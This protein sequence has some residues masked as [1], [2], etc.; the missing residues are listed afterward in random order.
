MTDLEPTPDELVNGILLNNEDGLIPDSSC[1]RDP[2]D[3]L[4]WF[5]IV[6]FMVCDCDD[7]DSV[8]LFKLMRLASLDDFPYQVNLMPDAVQGYS[9]ASAPWVFAVVFGCTRLVGYQVVWTRRIDRDHPRVAASVAP[10]S[11]LMPAFRYK[12]LARA[13]DEGIQRYLESQNVEIK[14]W[15][16]TDGGQ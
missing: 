16:F 15:S 12:G 5:S 7:D 13:L 14:P 10:E 11:W 9:G 8:S 2:L 4:L 3:P 6:S 1:R